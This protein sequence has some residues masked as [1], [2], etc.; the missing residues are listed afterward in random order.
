MSGRFAGKQPYGI[1]CFFL[2]FADYSTAGNARISQI[3]YGILKIVKSKILCQSAKAF[4]KFHIVSQLAFLYNTGNANSRNCYF[5]I[6]LCSRRKAHEN[7][8]KKPR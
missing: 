1:S 5:I 7:E 6:D 8:G 2:L 4:A 3:G